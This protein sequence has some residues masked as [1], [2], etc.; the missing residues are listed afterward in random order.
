[1]TIDV[2]CINKQCQLSHLCVRLADNVKD[3][4]FR[5]TAKFTPRRVD[6]ETSCVYFINKYQSGA[7][8]GAN[9]KPWG[10]K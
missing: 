2:G 8:I 9:V 6:D 1:M 4:R 3:K 5:Q 10:G 7:G